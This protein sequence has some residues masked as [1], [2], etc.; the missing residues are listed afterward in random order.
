MR[1]FY[2][3]SLFCL[4]NTRADKQTGKITWIQFR[5]S[6]AFLYT[7]PCSEL[8]PAVTL[9]S[10]L[11]IGFLFFKFEN[12]MF[13]SLT[14]GQLERYWTVYKK[15]L[16]GDNIWN[17]STIQRH[18]LFYVVCSNILQCFH[19]L[20]CHSLFEILGKVIHGIF[21]GNVSWDGLGFCGQKWICLGLW[22][23]NILNFLR[24]SSNLNNI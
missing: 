3:A 8:S 2:F 6:Q 9:A 14:D 22:S 19:G 12:Y 24:C 23:Q 1:R 21:K 16:Y 7:S 15:S 5:A 17:I 10:S 20:P 11:G 18:F 13:V 4:A